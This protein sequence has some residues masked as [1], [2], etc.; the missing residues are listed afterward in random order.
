MPAAFTIRFN[1][2]GDVIFSSLNP[3]L[4]NGV[5][6][7]DLLSCLSHAVRGSVEPMR[8]VFTLPAA[9]AAVATFAALLTVW[10]D[11]TTAVLRLIDGLA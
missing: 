7:S 4:T 11:H 5:A 8:L 9:F 1:V 3:K 6:I 10:P 2:A